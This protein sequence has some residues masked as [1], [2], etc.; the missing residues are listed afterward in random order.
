MPPQTPANNPHHPV[1]GGYNGL[2]SKLPIAKT[3]GAAVVRHPPGPSGEFNPDR[4]LRLLATALGRGHGSRPVSSVDSPL[5]LVLVTAWTKSRVTA[6][7]KWSVAM[8]TSSTQSETAFTIVV[9]SPVP[10]AAKVS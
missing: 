9:G 4:G 1:R 6:R 5:T 7:G 3:T 8:A 2:P 10:R